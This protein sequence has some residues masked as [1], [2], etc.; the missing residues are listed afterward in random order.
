LAM[1][2]QRLRALSRLCT[3]AGR[4]RRVQ[5]QV[6]VWSVGAPWRQR[7][8]ASRSHSR[9]LPQLLLSPAALAVHRHPAGAGGSLMVRVAETEIAEL[10]AGPRQAP[11]RIAPRYFYDR[12]GSQLFDEI[13]RT[14]EYYPTRTELAL[15]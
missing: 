12:V 10:F 4:A 6:H 2:P 9:N 13:T 3:G 1:D 7:G 14:P 5:R 8:D 15:L 11:P